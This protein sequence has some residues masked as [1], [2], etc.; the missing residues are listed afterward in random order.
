M[1]KREELSM[2]SAEAYKEHIEYTFNA[3]CRVVIRYAAINVWRDRNR[4]RQSV[5]QKRAASS[6]TELF[7]GIGGRPPTSNF[8]EQNRRV[9][10][11]LHCLPVSDTL[12]KPAKT[13]KTKALFT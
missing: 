10:T 8:A 2:T 9:C 13:R 3:F 1:E 6:G 11:T 12:E 4:P 7:R 5:S